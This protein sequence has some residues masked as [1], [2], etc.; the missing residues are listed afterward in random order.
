MGQPIALHT[1]SAYS[2]DAAAVV[3]PPPLMLALRL[4]APLPLLL[5]PLPLVSSP[6]RLL[7]L[8]PLPG[9]AMAVAK[10]TTLCDVRMPT[11]R[12]MR[13]TVLACVVCVFVCKGS[14]SLVLKHGNTNVHI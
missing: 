12:L 2:V 9:G 5:L 13:F 3:L 8:P 11:S 1:T 4:I 14:K 7:E 10:S 6:L